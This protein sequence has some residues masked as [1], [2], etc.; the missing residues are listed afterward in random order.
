M[1]FPV[2]M[3]TVACVHGAVFLCSQAAEK[4]ERENKSE[5]AQATCSSL[6]RLFATVFQASALFHIMF[7]FVLNDAYASHVPV[8]RCLI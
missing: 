1:A 2:K 8:I 5:C 3:F 7:I 6:L 4:R